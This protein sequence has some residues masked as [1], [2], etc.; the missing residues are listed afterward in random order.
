MQKKEK[1]R[2]ERNH[3]KD[4][5]CKDDVE[6]NNKKRTGRER[7]RPEQNKTKRQKQKKIVRMERC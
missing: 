2:S 7:K 6:M 3:K 5:Q 4:C 1:N